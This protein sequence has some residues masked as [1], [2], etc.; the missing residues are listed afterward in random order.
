MVG[1]TDHENPA[2]SAVWSTVSLVVFKIYD[3]KE[4]PSEG[5]CLS[6]LTT[7]NRQVRGPGRGTAGREAAR[8]RGRVAAWP[9]VK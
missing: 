6:F 5:V 4:S 7:R 9:R 3:E 1:I 8:P 2:V